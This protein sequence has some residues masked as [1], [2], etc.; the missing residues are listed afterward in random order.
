MERIENIKVRL[1]A[2]EYERLSNDYQ[3]LKFSSLSS[4]LRFLIFNKDVKIVF[5]PSDEE[6]A[7]SMAEKNRR[8]GDLNNQISKIG[9]NINQIAKKINS[10]QY[11]MREDINIILKKMDE[12][13]NMIDSKFID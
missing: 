7:R 6:F 8:I 4:Y 12:I 11:V 2:M 9:I 3:K 5:S 1:T 10:Q 13:K